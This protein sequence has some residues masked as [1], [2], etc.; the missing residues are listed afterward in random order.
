M[1]CK[2]SFPLSQKGAHERDCAFLQLKCPFHGQCVFNGSLADVVPHLAAEHAVTP[3]PVQPAGT[4]F[5]RAKNFYRRNIWTLIYSWD[6]PSNL[7]RFIVKHVHATQV[8][9]TDNCNLLIAHIQYIGPESMASRYAYQI[10]LFDA[11]RRATGQKFEGLV[12]STLKPIESQC[13]K[14]AD[15]SKSEVFVTTFAAARNYTDQWA[16]LNFIIRM[17]KLVEDE[18]TKKDTEGMAQSSSSTVA[19]TES[20]NILLPSTSSGSTS[21]SNPSALLEVQDAEMQFETETN[22]DEEPSGNNSQAR[23]SSIA[24][25]I[26]IPIV[27]SSTS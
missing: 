20:I 21:N 2:Q 13:A 6:R 19:N 10:C 8:G 26:N 4:L 9:R 23:Q 3:V 18:E 16:N 17:K 25:A 22:R 11:E 15:V 12:T 27:T 14:T 7:F 1:G 24:D 5:Y